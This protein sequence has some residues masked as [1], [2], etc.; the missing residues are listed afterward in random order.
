MRLS[1]L[2]LWIHCTAMLVAADPARTIHL[3]PDGDDD[4][5]GSSAVTAWRS[6]A[7]VSA[8]DL[9]PGGRVILAPGEYRGSDRL[10]GARMCG[11]AHAAFYPFDPDSSMPLTRKRWQTAKSTTSGRVATSDAAIR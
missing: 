11:P 2:L 7:K 6:L 5:D 9:G 4:R 8:L 3:A 10:D 1:A